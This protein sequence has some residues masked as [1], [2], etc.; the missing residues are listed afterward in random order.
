MDIPKTIT[1]T[2]QPKTFPETSLTRIDEGYASTRRVE[3]SSKNAHIHDGQMP[4]SKV[5]RRKADHTQ[6]HN[7]HSTYR[8]SN[9]G[10]DRPKCYKCYNEE[11][12]HRSAGQ[13][14]LNIAEVY[15]N[16]Q[17]CSRCACYIEEGRYRTARQVSLL[18][19]QKCMSLLRYVCGTL[20]GSRKVVVEL[21]V[22][23]PF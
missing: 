11:G 3:C 23:Y 6:L 4:S 15:V 16:A 14:P 7:R 5:E 20:A 17:I 21:H 18:V 2:S 19:W 12:R 9:H 10:R 13:V 22:N 1:P 8:G